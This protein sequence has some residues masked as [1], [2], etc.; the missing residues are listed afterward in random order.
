MKL[1]NEDDFLSDIEKDIEGDWQE[2]R[3]KILDKQEEENILANPQR[4]E[5]PR[6]EDFYKILFKIFRSFDGHSIDNEALRDL[7]V[8]IRSI[9]YNHENTNPMPNAF[10]RVWEIFCNPRKFEC[11]TGIRCEKCYERYDIL[12]ERDDHPRPN[13]QDGMR[14]NSMYMSH[15]RITCP[16]C[17]YDILH[18]A[19]AKLAGVFNHVHIN[20]N[21][22]YKKPRG[23]RGNEFKSKFE[24][25]F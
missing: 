14:G 1:V 18:L 24:S 10:E 15:C 9:F 20:E 11:K 16:S 4:M 22:E 12:L 19:G 8:L 3:K 21:E 5:L 2:I 13:W 6:Y 17:G 7:H 23:G 25:Y